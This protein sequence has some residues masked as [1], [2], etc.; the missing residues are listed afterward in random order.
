MTM[1]SDSW[2]RVTA[3]DDPEPFELEA[4]AQGDPGERELLIHRCRCPGGRVFMA[5]W[6]DT[7]DAKVDPVLFHSWPPCPEFVSLSFRQYKEFHRVGEV[8]AEAPVLPAHAREEKPKP[9]RRR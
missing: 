5:W 4:A 7:W 3:A 9:P 1:V 8:R 6:D 2:I